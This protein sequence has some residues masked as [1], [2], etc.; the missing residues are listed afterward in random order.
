MKYNNNA[1]QC[2]WI[3]SVFNCRGLL[4]GKYERGIVPS[5]PNS[6]RIA[7]VEA[8]KSSRSNQSHP[9]LTQ[10][11]D[12]DEY[13]ELIKAMKE[14]ADKHSNHDNNHLLRVQYS[15]LYYRC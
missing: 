3:Y 7:W 12:K 6:S 11:A 2:F 15:L 4:T 10:Y 9:S 13:W 5:D 8:D 1:V 14:I